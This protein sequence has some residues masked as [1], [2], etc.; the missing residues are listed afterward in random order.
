MM[1][2]SCE[3]QVAS[4]EQMRETPRPRNPQS[5]TRNFPS[6]FTFIEVLFA[7]ILLGIGFIMIAAVFP[8][9]IQQT[10]AVSSETQASAIARDA[11]KKI[12]AL[13]DAGVTPSATFGQTNSL[14]Q[15]T[16]VKRT[17]G[18]IVPVVC[19]FSY[20]MTQALGSDVFFSAD[21]RYGWV[22]FYRR[23]SFNSPYAEVYIVALQNPNFPSYTTNVSPGSGG[24]AMTPVP[25][26]LP[27]VA[28]PIPGIGY[29]FYNVAVPT[30]ANALVP[31]YSVNASSQA[32][33]GTATFT[34]PLIAG[35]G[36]VTFSADG[37]G[38]WLI[39]FA[40]PPSNAVPGAYVLIA[41]DGT[42]TVGVSPLLNGRILRL[43]QDQPASPGTYALQPGYD[44]TA[45]ELS[46]LKTVNGNTTGDIDVFVIG[47]A[48]TPDGNG[49]YTG[50]FTGPNQDI[51][52]ASAMIRVN[53]TN[54]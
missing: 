32:Y 11:I 20:A 48:P 33:N 25:P 13:A 54:N 46:Q 39:T 26:V 23:D 43:G 44:V 6:A 14:F 30:G 22:G 35:A 27:T 4:C 42:Q 2:N 34:S 16:L 29:N 21:H 51:G 37:N 31:T 5:P 3:L 38:G 24:S 8:V 50:P 49:G 41:D 47:R 19:G 45:T 18:A 10:A 28:P 1:K 15:P 36:F 17:A 9:A 52:A 53:T 40:S 12:Q 7:V